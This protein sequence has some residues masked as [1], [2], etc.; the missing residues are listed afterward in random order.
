MDCELTLVKELL[1]VVERVGV[2][3]DDDVG[4]VDSEGAAMRSSGAMDVSRWRSSPRS[5]SIMPS[6]QSCKG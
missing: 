5:P 3:G 4:A 1:D 6:S 2:H